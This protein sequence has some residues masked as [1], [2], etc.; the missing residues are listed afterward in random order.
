MSVPVNIHLLEERCLKMHLTTF[1]PRIRMIYLYIHVPP[2]AWFWKTLR[3]TNW[4]KTYLHLSLSLSP[5]LFPIPVGSGWS[6]LELLSLVGAV[7]TLTARGRARRQPTKTIIK[8]RRSKMD[9]NCLWQASQ[10]LSVCGKCSGSIIKQV[11][12][13]LHACLLLLVWLNGFL[14]TCVDLIEN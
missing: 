13:C 5:S 4:H 10:S 7:H 2:A 6:K 14:R 9:F 3:E 8:Y 12:V 11:T 1:F